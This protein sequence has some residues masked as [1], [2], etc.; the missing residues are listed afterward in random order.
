MYAEV[1][2]DRDFAALFVRDV[3]N[4]GHGIPSKARFRM[5]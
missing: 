4:P 3:V 5:I 1:D 2:L